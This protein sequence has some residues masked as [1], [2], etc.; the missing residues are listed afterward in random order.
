VENILQ[1][2]NLVFTVPL[3]VA[4]AWFVFSLIMSGV[5]AADAEAEADADVDA[6]VDADIDG[7]AHHHG[8][9]MA[10]ALSFL[11]FGKI[12]V[13][14]WCQIV[15]IL[16]GLAGLTARI[17][18]LSWLAYI[19]GGAA[20]LVGVTII[21]RVLEKFLPKRIES[22]IVP[23]KQRIGMVGVVVSTKVDKNYGEGRFFTEKGNIYMPIRVSSGE[24][25]EQTNV[26][27]MEMLDKGIALVQREE[28]L[29]N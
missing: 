21:S 14:L 28:D 11:G 5:D 26:V 9:D 18:G 10:T 7:D 25:P 27:V 16:W 6:D 20:A 3:G 8:L 29:L 24:L 2:E 12:P 1:P 23:S 17:L 15:F 4:L 22:D 19:V 13:V